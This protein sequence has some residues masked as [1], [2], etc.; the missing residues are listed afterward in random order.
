MTPREIVEKALSYS[1]RVIS[2]TD[3]DTT[4]GVLPAVEAAKGRPLEVVP[5]IE[6]STENEEREI[7]IL[8]YYISCDDLGLQ[9]KLADIRDKRVNRAEE[10]LGKLKRLGISIKMDQI[11]KIAGSGGSLGRPHIARALIQSGYAD[12]VSGAFKKYLGKEAPAYVPKHRL[13]PVE[14]L[15]MVREAGGIPVLA[16]PAVSEADAMMPALVEAGL[17]GL[18]AFYPD[19]SPLVAAHYVALAKRYHLLIT[20][21]SDYHGENVKNP[22]TIGGMSFPAAYFKQLRE[23][24]QLMG[25]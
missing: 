15:Q 19:H 23:A 20:G 16:H 12:S 22:V 2:I 7:H 18:E 3:H 21:G 6:L 11:R 24:H 25:G 9:R 14:A 10:I 4:D 1:L 5:G 13:L 17:M 8:G